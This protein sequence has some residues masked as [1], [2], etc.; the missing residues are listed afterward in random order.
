MAEEISSQSPQAQHSETVFTDSSVKPQSLRNSFFR[1]QLL[2]RMARLERG[3][4]IVR[5]PLGE[6]PLGT[7]SHHS[8]PVAVLTIDDIDTY[9][10]MA[11]GGSNGGAEAYLQGK[12]RTDNLTNVIR[13][14]AR[15]RHLVDQ[16]EGGLAQFAGWALRHWHN[17][18][19]N[20]KSGSRRNIAA[21]YDLGN[22]FFRLFLDE[23]MMYSS[24]LYEENDDLHQ[25]SERKLQRICDQLDISSEDHVVEIGSGWGGFAVFAAQTTGCRVTTITISQEQYDEAVKLVADNGLQDRVDVQLTDYRD[26]EGQYDKL[27][28]IEMIE[29]VG[30]HYLDTYFATISKV[31]KPGGKALIQAITVE[32]HRYQQ[33]LKEVDFIKRYIFPGSFIPCV[34]VIAESAGKQ[35]LVMEDLYDMGL[36]YARTLKDWRERFFNNIGVVKVHGF[37]ERFIR[38]W[39]FYLC[40]CEGGFA[41]RAISVVQAQFR[42]NI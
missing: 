18:N 37:D 21:H 31:L 39:D 4:L 30:H 10:D 11:L 5:D 13:I 22:D 40:Y 3:Q 42:K 34:S 17:R 23:R 25:A 41:E 14:M 2:Q 36:S 29:A 6:T 12:W 33:S 24:Y 27:V 28:S 8:D 15:N 16:M 38:M 35:T 20:S 32:D 19:R 9:K 26:L 1:Q 7:V